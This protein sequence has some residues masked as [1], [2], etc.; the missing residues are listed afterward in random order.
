MIRVRLVRCS[1]LVQPD[2]VEGGH[3]SSTKGGQYGKGKVCGYVNRGSR[4]H[5]EKSLGVRT[6]R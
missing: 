2:L 5:G 1:F 3:G 4:E 6:V